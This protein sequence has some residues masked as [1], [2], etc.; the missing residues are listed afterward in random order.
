MKNG[1]YLTGPSYVDDKHVLFVLAE[2]LSIARRLANLVRLL[3][4]FVVSKP[5]GIFEEEVQPFAERDSSVADSCSLAKLPLR[6]RPV[7]VQI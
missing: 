2:N 6:I 3:E 7:R 5:N 1:G 4:S